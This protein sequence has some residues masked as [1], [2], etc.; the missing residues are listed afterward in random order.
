MSRGGRPDLASAKLPAVRCPTLLIVGGADDAVLEL[1][2]EAASRLRCYH[3][4]PSS[5]GRPI[6]SRS[7]ERWTRWHG[8]Q[9]A[10][11]QTTSRCRARAR[12]TCVRGLIQQMRQVAPRRVSQGSRRS[13]TRRATVRLQAKHGISFMACMTSNGSRTRRRW[14]S[15]HG[16]APPTAPS[17]VDCAAD[18]RSLAA[19]AARLPFPPT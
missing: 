3:R 11:S 13:P 4:L 1:N 19:V 8:W 7:R 18:I 10:G 9:S 5:Q 12:A 6:C 2:R 16:A 17:A 15:T 14:C